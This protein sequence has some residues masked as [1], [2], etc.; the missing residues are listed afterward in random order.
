MSYPA[1]AEGLVNMIKQSDGEILV[2]LKLWGMQITSL[3]PSLPGPRWPEVVA[4]DRV[5][6]M[7]QIELLDFKLSANKWLM[8]IWSV[9]KKMFDH[10]TV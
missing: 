5:L 2:M 1:Q 4:P 6:S 8:L 3:W 9:F 10:L 7:G